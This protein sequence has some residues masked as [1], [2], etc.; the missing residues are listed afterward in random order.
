MNTYSDSEFGRLP[1]EFPVLK[2]D[3]RPPVDEDFGTPR[4]PADAP[5]IGDPAPEYPVPGS[6]AAAQEETEKRR[7]HF[8]RRL[9]MLA[10]GAAAFFLFFMPKGTAGSPAVPEPPTQ[11]AGTD[12]PGK[13][14]EETDAEPGTEP[15][16][17]TAEPGESTVAPAEP[18]TY[19][20]IPGDPEEPQI[21]INYAVRDGNTVRYNYVTGVW[22]R[23][24]ICPLTVHRL[25]YSP[26]TGYRAVPENDP[27]VWEGSRDLTEYTVPVDTDAQDL[28][29]VLT[30]TFTL[31][32]EEKMIRAV[33]DI[34]PMPPEP[35][36][37]STVSVGPSGISYEGLFIPQAG[38]DRVYDLRVLDF[39]CVTYAD[40]GA[41]IGGFPV[42][43]DAV[44]EIH[45]RTGGGF[46]F[47]YGGPMNQ[48]FPDTAA[49]YAIAL[50][51]ADQNTGLRYDLETE[52]HDVVRRVFEEP[53]CE[54]TAFN[55]WSE[56]HAGIVFSNMADVIKVT[57]EVWDPN[58]DY[59][60]SSTDIT[61]EAVNNLRYDV[62]PFT[63]DGIYDAN[64]DY[65]GQPGVD[66]PMTVEFR[67]IIEYNDESGFRSVTYSA[68]TSAEAG[69]YAKYLPEEEASWNP[70]QAGS[71]VFSPEPSPE[72][73]EIRVV[74]GQP[75]AV[76][77]PDVIS[78][79]GTFEG[80]PLPADA[81]RLNDTEYDA[82]FGGDMDKPVHCRVT[83][84]SLKRPDGV[85]ETDGKTVHLSVTHFLQ[86]TGTAYT[87]E[88]DVAFAPYQAE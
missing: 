10:A 27:D 70:S 62:K 63:T 6:A 88:M 53:G 29:L 33:R 48:Y 41:L 5:E 3:S 71:V 56:M 26:S 37:S 80:E 65:Y 85:R 64:Q 31:D 54:I 67:V 16:E 28:Q 69:F 75:E 17:T 21:V 86:S 45:A 12:E 47:F 60:D 11:Q 35:D 9:M 19:T 22:V 83:E 39:S 32:G 68:T 81:F 20:D 30:G 44:P 57:L 7:R 50:T 40:N 61:E 23:G 43:D 59:M 24:E 79:S 72:V 25:V 73:T 14:G 8:R 77:G 36:L 15:A 82:Y 66:F 51:V 38:D 1:E 74:V 46:A 58:T 13:P 49:S 84:V 87:S 18:E 52:R 76:T 55:F 4:I 78:I 2:E 34:I 42:Y